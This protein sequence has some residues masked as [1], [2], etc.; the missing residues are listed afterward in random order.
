MSK[1]YEEVMSMLL[2]VEGVKEHL[3]SENVLR[4]KEEAIK[5]GFL[6]DENFTI[7]F[8]PDGKME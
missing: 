3:E 5:S 2:S 6:K 7:I 8:T 4:F 1:D